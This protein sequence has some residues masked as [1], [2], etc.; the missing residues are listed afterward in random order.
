[1]GSITLGNKNVQQYQVVWRQIGQ[2]H[3]EGVVKACYG[4]LLDYHIGMKE[5][6]KQV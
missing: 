5:I 2:Q 1:M 6:L 4:R 3:F